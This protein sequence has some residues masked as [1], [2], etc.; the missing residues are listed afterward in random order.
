MQPPDG[1]NLYG[2]RS[3][4]SKKE[5]EVGN[6]YEK[7]LSEL[8]ATGQAVDRIKIVVETAIENIKAGQKSFVIFGEP[9]SGK[10]EMMIAL[11]ARL[12]DEGHKV[13]VVLMNDSVQL[14]GQNLERFQ[15]SAFRHLQRSSAKYCR[16]S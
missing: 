2:L 11:T 10:T 12:L 13:I 3:Q 15:R 1:A 4:E 6:R 5:A 14:L 16:P 9:Q 8:I 7:R